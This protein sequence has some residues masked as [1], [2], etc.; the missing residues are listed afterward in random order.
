[1]TKTYI[2]ITTNILSSMAGDSS[3]PL[4]IQV[5]FLR[6]IAYSL[7][8]SESL[9]TLRIVGDRLSAILKEASCLTMLSA[10]F[11]SALII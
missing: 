6:P 1:M 7:A 5:V 9:K 3:A 10:I 4:T 8:I 2:E 11:T